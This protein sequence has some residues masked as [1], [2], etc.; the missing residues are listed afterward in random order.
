MFFYCVFGKSLYTEDQFQLILNLQ[1][2][3]QPPINDVINQSIY[4]GCTSKQHSTKR[5]YGKKVKEKSHNKK[6][7]INNNEMAIYFKKMKNVQISTDNKSDRHVLHCSNASG[8]K[9]T[10]YKPNMIYHQPFWTSL[11]SYLQKV[12]AE[13]KFTL[14]KTPQFLREREKKKKELCCFSDISRLMGEL[15]NSASHL[16]YF[17]IQKYDS[18]FNGVEASQSAFTFILFQVTLLLTFLLLPQIQGFQF[19]HEQARSQMLAL[20]QIRTT[21]VTHSFKATIK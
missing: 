11:C 3:N 18:N 17:S 7:T 2:L 6:T 4:C 21:N 1:S 20:T 14:I 15:C 5:L 9:K 13:N 8:G 10:T 19:V 16:L 12:S